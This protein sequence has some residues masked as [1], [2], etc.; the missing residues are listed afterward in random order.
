M[1]RGRNGTFL[2]QEGDLEE[3]TARR[4]REFVAQ[5]EEISEGGA[6]DYLLRRLKNI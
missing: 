6:E 4:K 1:W 5:L 3:G 2:S